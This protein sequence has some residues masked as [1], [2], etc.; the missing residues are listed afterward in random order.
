[1]VLEF[2]HVE[3][4]KAGVSELLAAGW[5][6]ARIERELALC[7]VACVNCHRRRTASR[8]PS[9]RADPTSLDTNRRLLRGERR[10]MHFVRRLLEGSQCAD[11]G[12]SDLLV[13]EFDH[14]GSKRGNVVE[15]AR[16][17]CSLAVLE[18]E[19]AVCQVRCANCHRRRTRRAREARDAAA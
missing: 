5:S 7:E 2:D 16:R 14:I 19:I 18:A 9:W 6:I 11:C 17:G 15:L 10:N 3:T 4:K 8:D 1:M 12:V 13:L